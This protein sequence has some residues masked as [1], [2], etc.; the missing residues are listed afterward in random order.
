MNPEENFGVIL[1]QWRISLGLTLSELEKRTGVRAQVIGRIE[2]G[3][4]ANPTWNTCMK[5]LTG[6]GLHVH[7]NMR[8]PEQE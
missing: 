7:I 5:L 6:L 8:K 2:T 4:T 3:Y 1:H